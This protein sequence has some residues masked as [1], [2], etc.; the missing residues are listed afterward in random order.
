LADA[1]EK[2]GSSTVRRKIRIGLAILENHYCAL[3][4]VRESSL[5]RRGAKI[6][7]QQHRPEADIPTALP[8]VRYRVE[9]V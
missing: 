4:R 3:G 5:R 6:V 9:A 1:V 8:Y 2:G 7:L